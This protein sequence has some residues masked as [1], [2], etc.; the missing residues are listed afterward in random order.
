MEPSAKQYRNKF[1]PFLI[2]LIFDDEKEIEIPTPGPDH[3]FERESARMKIEKLV[4]VLF[5]EV[6]VPIS[7]AGLSDTEQKILHMRY[8]MQPPLSSKEAGKLL[9]MAPGAVDTALFRARKRIRDFYE[10]K[11]L[12]KDVL[13]V[14]RDVAW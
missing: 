1:A 12:L 8:I 3:L 10:A 5:E 2:P 9:G 4:D 11:G 7:K 13:E 6:L 14:L